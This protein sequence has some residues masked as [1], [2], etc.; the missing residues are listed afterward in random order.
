[1][2]SSHGHGRTRW[3]RCGPC[4][5]TADGSIIGGED[6]NEAAFIWDSA[7]GTRSLQAVLVND[8]GLG[9]SLTGWALRRVTGI[10]A[11]G[12][13][14]A[15]WGTDSAG[16]YEPWVAIVPEPYSLALG[17][18]TTATLARRCNRRRFPC[19]SF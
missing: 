5:A 14:L 19:D 7:H 4:N 11:D 12:R 9:S 2:D 8:Y 17:M 10:S 13:V 16:Q 15:G 6:N 1:M 3:S 18:M